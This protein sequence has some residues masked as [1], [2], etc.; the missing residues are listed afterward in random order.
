ME[1]AELLLKEI[2]NDCF[3]VLNNELYQTPNKY[4]IQVILNEFTEIQDYYY[5]H[6]KILLLSQEVWKLWSIR[7]IIDSADY[8]YDNELFDKVREFEKICK[9]LNPNYVVYKY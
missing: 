6:N 8:N 3:K 4:V 2:I 5:S 7:T 1:N 9:T